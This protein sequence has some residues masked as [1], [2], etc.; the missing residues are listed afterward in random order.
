MV[1]ISKLLL[2]TKNNPKGRGPL[3]S[4]RG[5]RTVNFKIPELEGP[6]E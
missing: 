3:V 5:A 2:D 1:R 4:R 6:L